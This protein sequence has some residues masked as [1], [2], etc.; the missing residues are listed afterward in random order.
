MEVDVGLSMVCEPISSPQTRKR[1]QDGED[2]AVL[3]LPFHHPHVV[4]HEQKLE[5]PHSSEGTNCQNG[6]RSHTR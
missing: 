5:D 6:V 2:S 1:Y 4:E 3:P